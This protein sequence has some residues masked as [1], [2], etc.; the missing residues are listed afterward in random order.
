MLTCNSVHYDRAPFL[1][2]R[3]LRLAFTGVSPLLQTDTSPALTRLQNHSDRPFHL[4]IQAQTILL[5]LHTLRHRI[6]R[7]P[8]RRWRPVMP[9]LDQ[10]RRPDRRRHLS[11][12]P[13]LPGRHHHLLLRLLRRL[14]DTM[15]AVGRV[16]KGRWP[17]E[18]LPHVPVPVDP[19]YSA[20]L[21]LS[22]RRAA[23]GVF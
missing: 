8:S 13:R 20:A 9:R 18:I 12:R 10:R 2:R 14:S 21:R 22:H 3:H 1:L 19:L 17:D 23:R 15:Q 16:A 11:R 7:P 4:P 6:T 5:D